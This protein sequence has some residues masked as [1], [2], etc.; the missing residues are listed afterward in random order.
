MN[1]RRSLRW[2]LPLSATLLTAMI[3]IALSACNGSGGPVN[4]GTASP[5]KGTASPVNETA[6]PVNETSFPV[7]E[8]FAAALTA[9]GIP[10]DLARFFAAVKMEATNPDPNTFIYSL[11]YPNGATREIEMKFT[12]NQQHTPTPEESANVP[13]G[14]SPIYAFAYA[15]TFGPDWEGR[16]DLHYFVP[17][18]GI[19]TELFSSLKQSSA[20][21]YVATRAVVSDV[22]ASG[23]SDAD[24]PASGVGVAWGEIAKT[25]ADVGIGSLI[26]H[27]KDKGVNVGKLGVI[28]ALGSA[29]SALAGAMDLSKQNGKWLS[30]LDA[31]EKC[32]ANPTNQVAKSDP[33]YSKDA[34]GR[35]QSAR[36]ELKE[37]NAVR[38]LNQMTETGSGSTPATAVLSIALKQ[39]FIWSEKT[40]GDYSENTIM[41]EARLAVVACEDP[42][43]LK[44]NVDVLS[45]WTST[46]K[47][48]QVDHGIVHVVSNVSWVW[49]PMFQQYHSQGT[50][51]YSS[52]ETSN[53]NGITC[54]VNRSTTGSLTDM[55][56]LTTIDDPAVQNMFGFGYSASG[57][58]EATVAAS[59]S[60][61]GTSAN[62]GETIDWLPYVT[63]FP[64][65]GGSIEGERTEPIYISGDVADGTRKVTYQ[66]SVPPKE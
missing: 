7:N 56:V 58:V 13:P 16:L 34:V 39:G 15:S 66:F 55:G 2:R 31:L 43:S 50:F 61:E 47:S 10:T 41:R 40:L 18:D 9:K 49:K 54:T 28:Y 30:E 63:G 6:S 26:D 59:Y 11:I 64:G 21:W 1:G 42:D 17:N 12:P 45:E 44:G 5:L 22:S 14:G 27:Y 23:V 52:I 53:L 51:T 24:A 3:V 48:G 38:F 33:N 25:G 57:S 29:A 60:C 36:S 46:W 20:R 37:V 35:I 8:T 32:A 62:I 65:P 19:P 4:N